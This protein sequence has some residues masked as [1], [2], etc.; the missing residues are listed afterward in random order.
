M[1]SLTKNKT[2]D[3]KPLICNVTVIYNVEKFKCLKQYTWTFRLY[4]NA[5]MSDYNFENSE[6]AD[7]SHPSW[8]AKRKESKYI[9][10]KYNNP[11]SRLITISGKLILLTYRLISRDYLISIF[12]TNKYANKDLTELYFQKK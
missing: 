6:Q 4:E 7:L 2:V 3:Y 5:K 9:E 10:Q 11:I 12:H 8:E 1:I